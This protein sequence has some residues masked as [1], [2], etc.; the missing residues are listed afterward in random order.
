MCYKRCITQAGCPVSWYRAIQDVPLG[1]NTFFLAREFFDALP[2]HQF[3]VLSID[4]PL[5]RP[6][7]SVTEV[8]AFLQWKIIVQQA[9]GR[10]ETGARAI[11][12][13]VC[14][15]GGGGRS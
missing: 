6:L 12:M 14:G 7:Q 1:E 9:F 4:F 10:W 15:G 13:L 8:I 2:V 11:K 5:Y 3:Q